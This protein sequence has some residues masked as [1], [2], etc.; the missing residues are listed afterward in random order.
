MQVFDTTHGESG[1]GVFAFLLI[2]DYVRVTEI[3][4]NVYVRRLETILIVGSPSLLFGI[5]W[6]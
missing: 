3:K 5:Y 1:S 2:Y 4:E 6:D